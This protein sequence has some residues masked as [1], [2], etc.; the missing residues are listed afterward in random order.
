MS[1]NEKPKVDWV[2][3]EAMFQDLVDEVKEQKRNYDCVIPVSGGKDSTWQVVKALEYGLKPICVTWRTPARNGLGQKNLD[4][5]ISLGV[6][7]LDFSVNPKLERKFTLKAFE[8]FGSPVIPMHMAI[9]AL[10]M[11]L[12]IEKNI[13]L[14]LWGENSA[15][16]YGGD[17]EKLKGMEITRS[18]LMQYGVTHGTTA[19]D[20][21]GND[22]SMSELAPYHWPEEAELRAKN[23]RAVFLGQY[24]SWDP[25]LTAK[26]VSE[27]GFQAASDAVV[28]IFDFAD[29][30]DAF[31]MS[32]HHWLKWY[33][34]GFTRTWDNLSLEIRAGRMTRTEAIEHLKALGDETPHKEIEMFCE[35][36]CITRNRFFEIAEKFRNLNI[37]E[38]RKGTWQIPNFLFGDKVW[39]DEN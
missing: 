36:T 8:R 6:D 23:V 21:V 10:P 9:H 33:K 16:E 27:H 25:K 38:K 31:L 2:N 1:S 19:Q 30:D 28:G 17:D 29:V 18:W 35:Y 26:F 11:Q 22:I 5:L 13:P 3:R 39:I 24:F 4:N 7:H 15:V 20:W 37:W 32:V 14:I 12:A 34:F